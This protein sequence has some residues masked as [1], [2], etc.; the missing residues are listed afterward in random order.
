MQR[1]LSEITFSDE[2]KNCRNVKCKDQSHCDKADEFICKLLEC[3]EI[4]ASEALP[5]PKPPRK[6]SS[7]S[8]AVPGWNQ[9]VK[10]F[11]DKAYFWHKVW[12]SAGKPINTELHRV[13]KRS[14]NIYHFQYKKCKKAEDTIIKSK[15]L[16]ACINGNGDIFVELRKLR[17]AKP[18][19]AT[20]MDGKKENIADHF[21]NI[22][23]ELYNSADDKD[24]LN[25]VLVDVEC[26]INVANLVEQAAKNL[27]ESK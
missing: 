21:K 4:S 13:M 9:S 24:D 1:L 20:S 18:T 8:K 12:I 10:P 25:E 23:E 2:A 19:V 14:R 7:K 22:F 15:V 26:K 6:Q 11:R 3:V 27:N 16:D 5:T 17:K